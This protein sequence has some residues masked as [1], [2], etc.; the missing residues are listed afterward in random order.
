MSEKERC[1]RKQVIVEVII[2]TRKKTKTD[3]RN[4]YEYILYINIYYIY[5]YIIYKTNTSI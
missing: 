2:K 3:Y 4:T 1:E 5:I